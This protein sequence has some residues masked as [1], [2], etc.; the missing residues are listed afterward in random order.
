[1]SKVIKITEEAYNAYVNGEDVLNET[2]SIIDEAQHYPDFLDNVKMEVCY[3]VRHCILGMIKHKK[4]ELKDYNIELKH[5]KEYFN[6][7]ILNV[8]LKKY[9]NIKEKRK[10]KATS[11]SDGVL[12]DNKLLG[13]KINV[14][15]PIS[16]EWKTEMSYLEYIV[17]HEVT[18]LFDDWENIKMGGKGVYRNNK[19]IANMNFINNADKSN[20]S[21]IKSLRWLAYL[22]IYTES[23]AFAQELMQEL[24][25]LQAGHFNIKEKF[26][27]TVSYN[28]LKKTEIEFNNVM[29]N[30]NFIDLMY[31]NDELITKYRDTSIPKMNQMQFNADKYYSMLTK[32]GDRILHKLS[33]RYFGVVQLYYDRL[34]EEYYKNNDFLVHD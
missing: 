9:N 21:L 8:K 27:E 17:S 34:Q 13:V 5:F 31:A 20:N 23:N 25:T 10:Y 12:K 2:K 30:A 33:R 24:K 14:T 4:T 1:M 3:N 15:A 26:K 16:D 18:H 28:N 32:W 19:T 29:K 6:S 11:F 22:S 7:F